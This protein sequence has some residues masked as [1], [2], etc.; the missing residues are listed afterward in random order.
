MRRETRRTIK[1]FLTGGE[2]DP[3]KGRREKREG[4]EEV[5]REEGRERGR[6]KENGREGR[7]RKE[8]EHER[9]REGIK[10]N[11]TVG[12]FFFA[13]EN[14]SWWCVGVVGGVVGGGHWF[15]LGSENVFRVGVGDGENLVL[16]SLNFH[17]EKKRKKQK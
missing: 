5:R 8:K 14:V 15:F 6:E 9:R 3:G 1:V 13:S 17:F 16:F 10:T 11:G 2:R 7:K 12:Q 4:K